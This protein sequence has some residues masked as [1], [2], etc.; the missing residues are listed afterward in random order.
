MNEIQVDYALLIEVMT[1]E[2]HS[3]QSQI[4]AL[5]ARI[6]AYDKALTEALNNAS[7]KSTSRKKAVDTAKDGG[8]F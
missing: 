8:S 2:L 7:P 6:R 3:Y 1:E 4:I 5:K